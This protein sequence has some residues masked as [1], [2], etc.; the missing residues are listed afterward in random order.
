MR[1]MGGPGGG[2]ARVIGDGFILAEFFFCEGA[3]VL[4]HVTSG[5]Y[6][7]NA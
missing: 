2:G 1:G 4:H 7:E 3:Y 6:D 5:E